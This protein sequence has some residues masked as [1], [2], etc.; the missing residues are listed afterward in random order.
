MEATNSNIIE[1]RRPIRRNDSISTIA[2]SAAAA[3]MQQFTSTNSYGLPNDN[4]I[5]PTNSQTSMRF[6][7]SEGVHVGNI[8][9]HNYYQNPPEILSDKK[10]QENSL[11]SSSTSE[12]SFKKR[13]CFS[14]ENKRKRILITVIVISLVLA[15]SIV[16]PI[17]YFL[18]TNNPSEKNGD[19]DSTTSPSTTYVTT[20]PLPTSF[21]IKRNEW[22]A[23]E[24]KSDIKKLNQPI[25]RIIIGHTGGNFC[26]NTDECRLLVKQIQVENSH[27]DDI[28]YNYLIGGDG[29]VYE[30]RGF[31]FEGQHTAN[32]HGTE[33]NSI[34]ICI[35]FIGNYNVTSPNENQLNVL[36]E[37]INHFIS[38][39]LSEDYIIIKQ[40]D[41]IYKS[42]KANALNEAIV[43]FENYYA[44]QTVYRREE[45]GALEPSGK[46]E[47]FNKIMDLTLLSHTITDSCSS[48][49]YC[50]QLMRTM[51]QTNMNKNGFLDYGFNFAIGGNGLIFEGRGF[52]NVGAHLKI[53]N[54]KS[55]GIAA[56]GDF[57][58][59]EPS[60]E[61]LD[62]L[63]KFLE[64]AVKLGKLTQDYRVNGRQDFGWEGPGKN[65]MK[66]IREWCRYGNRTTPC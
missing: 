48:M 59:N 14:S 34:G 16:I 44:L 23:N 60:L 40:D 20:T 51:Q 12:S 65:I 3:Q 25:K 54:S 31:E 62:T 63:V 11:I 42:T 21:L 22:N 17:T 1:R 24:P 39:E 10:I 9:Y 38:K 30:G 46:L 66:F 55:I 36:R 53:L 58:K 52:D 64:D 57:D 43:N 29:K 27:L 8:I 13:N 26:N 49:S 4:Q 61:M 41:L 28:P 7:N 45:W 2:S 19:N 47:K 6:D 15:I 18:L 56:I 33:F 35:A 5:I 50:S 32:L 37:F